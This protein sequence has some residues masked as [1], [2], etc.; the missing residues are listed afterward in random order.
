MAK[1]LKKQILTQSSQRTQRVKTT[2]LK[3]QITN[4]PQ[5]QMTET[6]N[7]ND[8]IIGLDIVI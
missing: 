1:S 8:L 7:Q 2:N 5:Y 4:K 3:W 6:E